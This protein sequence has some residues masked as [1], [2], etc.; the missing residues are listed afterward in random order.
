[1]ELTEKFLQ[2]FLREPKE[3]VGKKT[4]RIKTKT[5]KKP[6]GK[7]SNNLNNDMDALLKNA[8]QIV[9]WKMENSASAI[10]YRPV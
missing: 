1:M 5:I 9:F 10:E 7:V 6:I 2:K 3:V 8:I 4:S